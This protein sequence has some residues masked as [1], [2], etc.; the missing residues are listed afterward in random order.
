MLNSINPVQ[1]ATTPSASSPIAGT[2][3]SNS[4]QSSMMSGVS[5]QITNTDSLVSSAEYIQGSATTPITTE[6]LSTGIQSETDSKEQRYFRS[7]RL[8]PD[9][10]LEQPWADRKDPR[11]KW[12][13]I[14]PLIGLAT[15]F[16][17]AAYMIIQGLSTVKHHKYKLV[18]DENWDTFDSKIWTKESNIGGFG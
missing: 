9:E 2:L 12:V 13:T 7:R 11:E 5:A 16:A 14:I 10:K 17:F 15:G 4:P 3:P 18:L 6:A 1:Q 8:R